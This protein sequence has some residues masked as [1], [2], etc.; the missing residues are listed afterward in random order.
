[1]TKAQPDLVVLDTDYAIQQAAETLDKVMRMATASAN[2]DA[3]LKVAENWLLIAAMLDP[4]DDSVDN[5]VKQK[6]G[7]VS[8]E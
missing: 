2:T 1:M 4:D 6:A 7:F 8:H 3:A 5:V